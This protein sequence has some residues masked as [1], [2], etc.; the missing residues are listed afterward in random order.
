METPEIEHLAHFRN[1]LIIFFII[2]FAGFS[3]PQIYPDHYVDFLLNSGIKNVI[4]NNYQKADSIFT[5]LQNKYPQLPLGKIYLAAVKIARSFDLGERF[6]DS[7][8]TNNLDEAMEQSK[9]L[10]G[11]NENN[12]WYRYFLALSQGYYAYY[13]AI[14]KSWLPALTNGMDAISNINKCL[15]K[16]P[17]FY[18]AYIGIGTLKYWKSR[19]TEL[20][21]WFPFVKN[22]E[23]EGI[24]LLKIAVD[25]SSYNKYLAINSLLWIYID[26]HDYEKAK[27]LA[28][29]AL[30]QF[31]GSR[32]FEWGLARVYEDINKPES[33]KLYYSIYNSYKN[34]NCLNDFNKILIKHKIAQQYY[35]TG[36]YKKA[37]NLCDEI[38]SIKNIPEYIKAKLGNRLE[39]VK[40]LRSKLQKELTG[41]SEVKA[42]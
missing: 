31:P 9:K 33:I 28:D 17:R 32:L 25:S 39:R 38:L 30:K 19:K 41:Q 5:V 22:E 23:A 21:A 37:L 20:L 2:V 15:K 7:F 24:K 27:S 6:D 4:E 36:N 18:E 1:L 16:D 14:N 34:N 35:K 10:L 3:Y 42:E 13:N 8:I 12:I 29:T 40:V 11:K 26:K